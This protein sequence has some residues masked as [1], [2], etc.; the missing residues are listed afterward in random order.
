MAMGATSVFVG[1][2]ENFALIRLSLDGDRRVTRQRQPPAALTETHRDRLF[3]M[4]ARDSIVTPQELEIL[5][6]VR[7]P[8]TLPGFGFE[9][10]TAMVGEQALLVTD[11]DEVWLLA[12]RLP[13]D[14]AG[15]KWFRLDTEGVYQGTFA[16]PP[17]C[18]A[19]AV[20]QN[21]VLAICRDGNDVEY[22]H[23]FR[24]R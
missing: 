20:R 12:F 7:G 11:L 14:S 21:V 22:V 4:L 19:T 10:F 5:R 15:E 24:F 23:A 17:A 13:D 16:M 3:A 2:P 8:T 1:L 9:P 18:R 6:E